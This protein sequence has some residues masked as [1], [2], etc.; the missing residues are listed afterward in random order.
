MVLR[1]VVLI[2]FEL[3]WFGKKEI[4]FMLHGMSVFQIYKGWSYSS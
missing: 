3:E 4:I 1:E 2:F